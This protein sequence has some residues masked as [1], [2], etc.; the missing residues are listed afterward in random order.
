V[1]RSEI[2]GFLVVL[3]LVLEVV[4]SAARKWMIKDQ[5]WRRLIAFLV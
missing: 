5:V 2:D 1:S 4:N 3:H